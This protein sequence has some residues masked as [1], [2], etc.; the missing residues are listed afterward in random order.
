MW[1][2]KHQRSIPERL[3]IRKCETCKNRENKKI[4]LKCISGSNWES[5]KLQ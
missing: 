1:T 4:C 5:N 2:D 3:E